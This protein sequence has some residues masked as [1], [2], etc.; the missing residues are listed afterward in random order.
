MNEKCFTANTLEQLA[1][2]LLQVYG[3]HAVEAE[4][5][6][7]NLVWCDKIGRNNYGMWRI[8]HI[9][10]RLN[11]GLFSSPANISFAEKTKNILVLNGDNGAGHVVAYL[12]T[13]KVIELAKASGIG[14]VGIHNS[15]FFGAS[16]YYVNQMAEQGL[17]G[18]AMSNS[19][20]KV[21]PYQGLT[22]VFGTNPFAFA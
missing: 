12:G 4:I 16:A 14:L 19:F 21:V 13:Q 3:L 22:A 8:P 2:N 11:Y 7:H 6:S 15:N 17:I 5:V 9:I 1:K 10:K 20:P 18:I